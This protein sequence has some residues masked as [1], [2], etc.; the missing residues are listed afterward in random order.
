MMSRIM[1]I[2]VVGIATALWLVNL[3][4]E[5]RVP[6][7]SRILTFPYCPD[8]LWGPTNLLS[9][10]YRGSFPGGRANHSRPTSAEAKKTWICTATLPY[11]FTE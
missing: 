2:S 10:G 9:S 5:V 8:R 1:I 7:W 3:G 11:A 4:V 6:V